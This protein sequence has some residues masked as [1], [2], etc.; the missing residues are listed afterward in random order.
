MSLVER[1]F[2][3][4]VLVWGEGGGA[5][6]LHVWMHSGVAPP[7]WRGAQLALP[8]GRIVVHRRREACWHGC[9]TVLAI[10]PGVTCDNRP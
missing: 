3:I 4:A 6:G 2:S 8:H 10:W 5:A 1:L 9:A 7:H